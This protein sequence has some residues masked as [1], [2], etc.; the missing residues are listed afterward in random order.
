MV[1]AAD[2]HAADLLSTSNGTETIETVIY[3]P[4]HGKVYNLEFDHAQVLVA[5][6][7][8]AG[9]FSN[10]NAIPSRRNC[11]AIPEVDSGLL[12]E[13]LAINQLLAARQE[14]RHS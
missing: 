10:Q 12:D 8:F 7:I 6:D 5:N 3:I 13:L 2:L 11:K 4:Y 14:N 1:R 9:D